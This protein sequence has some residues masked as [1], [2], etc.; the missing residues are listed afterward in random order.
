MVKR[1]PSEGARAQKERKQ[2]VP[3]VKVASI[4]ESKIGKNPSK[5][6]FENRMVF[7]SLSGSILGSILHQN[8]TQRV[9]VE[10]K[11]DQKIALCQKNEFSLPYSENQWI[12]MNLRVWG[13][14]FWC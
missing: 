3:D 13:L 9:D 12:L 10:T 11:I 2:G 14:N 5:H 1:G 7:K 8:G 4:L 6:V